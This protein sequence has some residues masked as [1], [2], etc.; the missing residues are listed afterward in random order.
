MTLVP[1][2]SRSSGWPAA[3]PASELCLAVIDSF[4]VS[5]SDGGGRKS[6]GVVRLKAGREEAREE[7]A[8]EAEVEEGTAVAVETRDQTAEVAAGERGLSLASRNLSR[9][10]IA[11]V[12]LAKGSWSRAGSGRG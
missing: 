6:R 10:G 8:E 2:K 12:D 1:I 11:S 3:V 4:R 5:D 7:A 9:L